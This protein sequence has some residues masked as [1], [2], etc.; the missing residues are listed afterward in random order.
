[1]VS[2]PREGM[3]T[4]DA[5][6]KAVSAD[7]GVPTCVVIGHPELK[8]LTPSEEHLPMSV[9]GNALDPR[10]GET[11]Y[12]LPRHVCT[13]VDNFSMHC[14]CSTERSS[15]SKGYLHAGGSLP[16]ST[17]AAA[18]YASRSENIVVS[19]DQLACI[20]RGKK[21]LRLLDIYIND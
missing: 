4:C 10:H 18:P 1:M 2:R 17:R 3:R 7:A 15:R 9:E 5:G 8:P 21:K 12:L 19:T 14:W 11:L 13:T 16:C 20:G 6:H